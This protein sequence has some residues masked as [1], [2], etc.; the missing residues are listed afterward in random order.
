MQRYVSKRNKSPPIKEPG[1]RNTCVHL[2]HH[3]R[4]TEKQSV[5]AFCG[6]FPPGSRMLAQRDRNNIELQ[7][8][9]LLKQITKKM[10]TRRDDSA[11]IIYGMD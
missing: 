10:C 8:L 4:N 3:I 2:Y 1:D 9:D 11:Y 5:P 6:C 7:E